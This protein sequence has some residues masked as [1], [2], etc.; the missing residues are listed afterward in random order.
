ME[1]EKELKGGKKRGPEERDAW[2][3][4]GRVERIRE[5]CQ[6]LNAIS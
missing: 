6:S 3:Q 5:E 2:K 1:H 4:N